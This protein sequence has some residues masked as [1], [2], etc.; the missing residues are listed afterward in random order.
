MS[1]EKEK[2]AQKGSTS[3]LIMYGREEEEEVTPLNPSF[4]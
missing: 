2:N 3:I 1:R 4:S